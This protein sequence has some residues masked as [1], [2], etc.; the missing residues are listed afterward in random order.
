MQWWPVAA[1]SL[2]ITKQLELPVPRPRLSLYAAVSGSPILFKGVL[3]VEYQIELRQN[4]LPSRRIFRRRV[5]FVEEAKRSPSYITIS[6]LPRFQ[7]K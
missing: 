1:A 5:S 2:P 6:L 3:K 4:S 7:C